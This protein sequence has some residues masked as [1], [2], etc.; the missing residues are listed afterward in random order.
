MYTIAQVDLKPAYYDVTFFH[1]SH[2]ATGSSSRYVWE[3]F[4]FDS[5]L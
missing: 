4:E 5:T 3:V 2:S 1:V